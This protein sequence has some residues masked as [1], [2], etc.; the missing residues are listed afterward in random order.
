MASWRG[1]QI[2]SHRC[3]LGRRAL[4][5]TC[6]HQTSSGMNISSDYQEG[7]RRGADNVGN[8]LKTLRSGSSDKTSWN[9]F[10]RGKCSWTHSVSR[11]LLLHADV[12]AWTC[13]EQST[14]SAG[15]EGGAYEE[16]LPVV[17]CCCCQ[18]HTPSFIPSK[19]W[20]NWDLEDKRLVILGRREEGTG[21]SGTQ[22]TNGVV[23]LGQGE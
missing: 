8:L 19:D 11:R 1:P 5:I 12:A 3:T 17:T 16:I 15:K 23:I 7:R 10:C 13:G 4:I 20:L 6:S 14:A 2:R 18:L 21:Y 22:R 9:V